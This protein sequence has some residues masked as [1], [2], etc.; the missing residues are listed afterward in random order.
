LNGQSFETW[1]LLNDPPLPGPRN[2]ARDEALLRAVGAGGSP[3]VLRLYAWSPPTLS[4]GFG[5]RVADADRDRLVERNWGL[6]R[7]LT[8]GRAILHTDELT[9]CIVLPA[10][11]P[12]AQGSVVESYRRISA[13]FAAAVGALGG[14]TRADRASARGSGSAVC[15]ETP[16][17][18]ELTVNGRKL[19]GSAQAR[20]V[21]GVLQH[22]SLPLSG[23]LGRIVDVLAFPDSE[24]RD[25]ARIG[26]RQRAVTLGEALGRDVAWQEAASTLAAAVEETFAVQLATD[27]WSTGELET[28]NLL[29]RDVY[30]AESWTARR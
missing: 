26:V 4:L 11:H 10:S 27:G 21:G 29:E 9:Y 25:Q 14:T 28:A 1:R 3:P 6:V 2:M 5:Q 8:G 20:R 15:F 18:Y 16:S 30:A 22:G 17:H 23:D 13:A 7:R 24:S 12:L 19:V